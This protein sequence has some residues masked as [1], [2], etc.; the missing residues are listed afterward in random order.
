MIFPWLIMLYFDTL[1]ALNNSIATHYYST[2]VPRKHV[3]LKP[4]VAY[5]QYNTWVSLLMYFNFLINL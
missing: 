4:T 2:D 1:L 3:L 5:M